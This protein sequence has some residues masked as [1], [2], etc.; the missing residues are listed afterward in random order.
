[1]E[2]RKKCLSILL[3]T[4]RKTEVKIDLYSASEWPDVSGSGPDLFRIM[5]DGKWQGFA[6]ENYSFMTLDA[7]MDYV[8]LNA[9]SILGCENIIPLKPEIGPG[10]SVRVPSRVL[11]GEQMYDLTKCVTSPLQWR[12]G[13][14]YAGVIIIGRGTE[15]KRV[16]EMEILQ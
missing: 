12:D 16:D 10:T 4:S 1:M 14:W 6:D 8:E 7:A 15:L 3:L 2:K 9:A 11:D 5:V 13:R